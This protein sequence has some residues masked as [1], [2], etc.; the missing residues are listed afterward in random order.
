MTDHK[1]FNEMKEVFNALRV[2]LPYKMTLTELAEQS[3]LSKQGFYTAI[4]RN[5]MM[6]SNFIKV[7]RALEIGPGELLTKVIGE[8]DMSKH[9]P[10][11][12]NTKDSGTSA[13]YVMELEEYN[14][15][16]EKEV[17]V[18]RK[19]VNRFRAESTRLSQKGETLEVDK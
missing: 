16:L 5:D 9:L 13:G 19:L 14:Q 18:L 15:V 3:G 1:E 11:D 2:Q 10:F 8:D 6:L 4:K 12:E 17:E 7:A